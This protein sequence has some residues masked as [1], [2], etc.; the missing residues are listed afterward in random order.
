[1]IDPKTRPNTTQRARTQWSQDA[2]HPASA[3][4]TMPAH[5]DIAK[6]AYEIYVDKGR[7][8]GQCEQDWLQA[9]G[10][11]LARGVAEAQRCSD[12][13]PVSHPMKASMSSDC[14]P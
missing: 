13:R 11:L 4:I 12:E 7:Q 1:M 5:D 2:L 9:E 8:Q 10:D 14:G 6:R 3:S